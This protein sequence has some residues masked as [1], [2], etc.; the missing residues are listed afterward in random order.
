MNSID[1]KMKMTC[2]ACPEQYDVL[3]EDGTSVIG[4]IRLRYGHFKVEAYGPGG[5]T[6]V[7]RSF[8]L[9]SGEATAPG[10]AELPHH[11]SDGIFENYEVRDFYLRLAAREVAL[12]TC[13]YDA[14]FE[15]EFDYELVPNPDYDI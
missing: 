9:S 2:P 3:S 5:T 12:Y 1:V 14:D 7:D 8:P 11:S 13:S 6:L 15:D 4:Y 10:E